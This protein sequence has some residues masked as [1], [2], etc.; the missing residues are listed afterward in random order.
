MDFSWSKCRISPQASK[1]SQWHHL[2]VWSEHP[3]LGKK[4]PRK[5][6]RSISPIYSLS[7]FFWLAWLELCDGFIDLALLSRS[8]LSMNN[9]FVKEGFYGIRKYWHFWSIICLGYV[10]SKLVWQGIVNTPIWLNWKGFQVKLPRTLHDSTS[11][12][13]EK[14]SYHTIFCLLKRILHHLRSHFI[15]T[16]FLVPLQTLSPSLMP[17][18]IPSY[19]PWHHREHLLEILLPYRFATSKDLFHLRKN[20]VDGDPPN[21]ALKGESLKKPRLEPAKK[22]FWDSSRAK[23]GGTLIS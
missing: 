2:P 14:N 11:P 15:T 3:D 23:L 12:I 16:F 6:Q 22:S 21:P 10:Q 18:Q 8:E 17:Y 20:I 9:S 5:T 4:H 13:F 19:H 7:T 1:L